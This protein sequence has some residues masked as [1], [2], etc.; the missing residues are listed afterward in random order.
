MKKLFN[1]TSMVIMNFELR[2]KKDGFGSL[3][4]LV[5]CFT[6]FFSFGQVYTDYIGVGHSNGVTVTTSSNSNGTNGINTVNANGITLDLEAASRFLAQATLGYDYEAI[7]QVAQM[8]IEA[9]IE[10]EFTKPAT[11]FQFIEQDIFDTYTAEIMAVHGPDAEPYRGSFNFNRAFWQHTITSND[12][13]RQRIA[14]AL[15]QIFVISGVGS[16]E[17]RGEALACFYDI[18]YNNAFGNYRNMI[19]EITLSPAMGVY[20][21]HINNP[22]TNI[23]ENIRPDENYAREIMQLF[24]IGLY[25]LNNDGT[26]Q[27]DGNGNSIPS[28][29]N[30][31][32]K[33]FAKIF[34]G[35]SGG[36]WAPF[37]WL[38]QNMQLYFGWWP[39]DYDMCVPMIMWENEHQ[40][41][42]KYLLNGTIVPAGQTGMQ[43]INDALDNLFTHPN[44][45][46][47]IGKKL[48]QFLVKSN[49]SPAYVSRVAAIFNDNGNGIRGDMEAV[50]KAILID[51]EARN[52]SWETDITAGKMRE[53]VVRFTQ[54]N[55]AFNTTNNSGRYWF[56]DRWW[57]GEEMK[58]SVMH[59]PSVFN[60][61]QQDFTPNGIINNN[62]LVA[63]E[64][65]ILDSNTGINWIN[66]IDGGLL[67][68]PMW[69]EAT[70]DP[71]EPWLYNGPNDEVS[72]DLSDEILI[73]NVQGFSPLIDRLNLILCNGQLEDST[74]NIILNAMNQLE[75][76][77]GG[78]DSEYAV[79]LCI[80]YI[81]SSPDYVIV[82]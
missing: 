41:G 77:W 25:E 66:S 59:S 57:I 63:P 13:L 54:F 9:W 76:V 65:K 22:K 51:V 34:T 78:I 47:F 71:N 38:D 30:N 48:I 20:L 64:F 40:P 56:I 24:S 61:F 49:P 72:Y 73:Y 68:Q 81:L 10:N 52:C 46:P 75:T 32:V 7:E 50:I 3:L 58:Q 26:N 12:F 44:V 33:E 45:G 35:L 80:Y 2:I 69:V 36:A 6:S 67:W 18:L 82:R 62:N 37:E 15:S 55:K 11:S 23:I 1:Q 70:P 28:Y 42:P 8:G 43:D 14:F 29:D 5:I 31:D 21:S 53:P 39:L 74:K 17:D 27:V 16:L 4:A 60:F 19:E 79:K